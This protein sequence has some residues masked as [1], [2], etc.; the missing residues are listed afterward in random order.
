MELDPKLIKHAGM[1]AIATWGVTEALKPLVW[2]HVNLAWEKVGVRLLALF[3]GG[4]WGY[5][6]GGDVE[7]LT[8]GVCGAA[9]SSLIVAAV[10]K[11]IK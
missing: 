10:R 4:A 1:A 3:I 9:L 2:K 11:R 5:T 7:S 6:L 8:A